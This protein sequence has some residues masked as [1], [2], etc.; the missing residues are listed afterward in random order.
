MTANLFGERFAGYR[1][2]AWHD[3]GMV[4]NTKLTPMEAVQAA[5]LN[6]D[7]VKLP[8]NATLKTGDQ[9]DTGKFGLI[10]EATPDSP[11][12]FL[13]TVSENYKYMQNTE[14]AEAISPLADIWPVETAGALG[15]GETVFFSLDVGSDQVAG[16]EIKQYFLITDTR[17]GGTS[18]R[19]MFTPVR[20]VCQNTL[21]AG[22]A[23]AI[24]MSSIQHNSSLKS[25]VDQRVELIR[26]LQQISIG[27]M[28]QF[29]ALAAAA[30][31]M[32]GVNR[33][34][35]AAFPMPKM[36]KAM[37]V[38]DYDN[39]EEYGSL[40]NSAVNAQQSYEYACSRVNAFRDGSLE[41]FNMFNDMQPALANTAWAA[42]NAV[43]ECADWR[44]GRNN[45]TSTA[46]SILFGGRAK[47]KTRAFN[48]AIKMV[49]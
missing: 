47:E 41:L 30:I 26:K 16:E 5:R 12:A 44:N 45:D 14:V 29:S 40:F 48:A 23:A 9:I 43:A 27:T 37:Q 34:I 49:A 20:V 46:N 31:N 15:N 7:I 25:N 10:R 17:D 19:I 6:F 32:D 33:I 18:M 8:L 39:A 11:A 3:L 42:Y 36:P 24:T 22:A 4:F 21:I 2:P 1:K 35:E 28:E 38:L 13:G